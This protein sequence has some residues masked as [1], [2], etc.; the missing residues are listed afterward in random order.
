MR[1]LAPVHQLGRDRGGGARNPKVGS[2]F[3]PA[4]PKSCT[5]RVRIRGKSRV[6][7]A[8]LRDRKSLPASVRGEMQAR[9][10]DPD[11][12]GSGGDARGAF[13]RGLLSHFA[14]RRLF[15]WKNS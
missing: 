5:E 9:A 3:R 8:T 14:R 11:A 4:G 15:P 6:A 2:R 12:G 1:R 7:M 10:R 13:I